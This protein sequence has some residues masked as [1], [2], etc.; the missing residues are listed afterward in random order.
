M[1]PGR[2]W[3]ARSGPAPSTVGRVWREARPQPHQ[4]ETFKHSSDPVLVIRITDEVGLHLARVELD[5]NCHLPLLSCRSRLSTV[6][7]PLS[8]VQGR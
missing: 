7:I 3:P 5:N 4:V 6:G 1:E 8:H 2:G